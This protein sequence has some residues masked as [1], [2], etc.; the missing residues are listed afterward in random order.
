M[1]DAN[2]PSPNNLGYQ[3]S[4][5]PTALGDHFNALMFIAKQV[6]SGAWTITLAKVK[7]V[8]NAGEVKDTGTVSLQPLVNQVDA[9]GNA[10]PH[11]TISNAIYFRYGGKDG[12]IICDPAVGD[13]PPLGQEMNGILNQ[14]TQVQQWQQAGGS[15]QFDP[16]FA[17]AIGG[18][19]LGAVLSSK[20]VLGRQWMSTVDN[21]TTD[22]DSASAANWTPPPG[23]P[24]VGTPVP[25]FS[26]VV[27][28]GYVAANALRIGNTNSGA[29]NASPAN[30][31]LFRFVWPNFSN[32]QCPL[33]NSAGQTIPRGAN[34]D[35]DWNANNSITLPDGRGVGL[36]GV[37]GMGNGASGFLNGIPVVIGNVTTPGSIIGENLH[38]LS[39]NELASHVHS[40]SLSDPSHTH[41]SNALT[42]PSQGVAGQ[43]DFFTIRG[44]T[45]ASINGA[46]T[47]ISLNNA[48][49]GGNAFHN[50]VHRS[51]TV[52]WNLAQ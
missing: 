8:T 18:Y 25:S 28:A 5:D 44:P 42:G 48:A 24:P 40:S 7:S 14:I 23:Q 17:T 9:Q 31:L 38:Q 3:G 21:N 43:S 4:A 22:P 26:P 12:A 1:S 47:G 2:V 33:L 30:L 27:P 50:T 49:Q 15:W 34:P 35:A 37:D 46:F 29:N 45:P 36:I 32:A 11:G 52:Y 10:T 39:V 41:S 20:V 19:P 16:N 13:I 51:M 6:L